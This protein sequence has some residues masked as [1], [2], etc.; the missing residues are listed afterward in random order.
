MPD[1]NI[2]KNQFVTSAK[3]LNYHTLFQCNAQDWARAA[4]FYTFFCIYFS[5]VISIL[6]FKFKQK[7]HDFQSNALRVL[8]LRVHVFFHFSLK[9]RLQS[10][11]ELSLFPQF[12][13]YG[14]SCLMKMCKP[15]WKL[16]K[17]FMTNHQSNHQLNRRTMLSFRVLAK[18]H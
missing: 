13:A 11:C 17:W 12:V 1:V 10:I 8:H 14:L 7:C 15:N 4:C 2:L 9:M 5:I 3:C 18:W 6:D 16:W